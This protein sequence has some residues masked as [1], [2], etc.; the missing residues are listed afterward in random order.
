MSDLLRSSR[1]GSELS[2][3]SGGS[4]TSSL[5]DSAM[6]PDSMSY[7]AS[8]HREAENLPPPSPVR[9]PPLCSYPLNVSF[10]LYHCLMSAR[11][12]QIMEPCKYSET[13]GAC[14]RKALARPE[15]ALCLLSETLFEQKEDIREHLA[16][17]LH[18]LTISLDSL[19]PILQ[20]HAQQVRY[21]LSGL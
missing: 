8:F 19:Q 18:I 21:I 20:Q 11:T 15:M 10:A 13:W 12:L 1:A 3:H 17:L 14:R 5:N 7:S 2:N 6:L 16:A 9:Y 4:F